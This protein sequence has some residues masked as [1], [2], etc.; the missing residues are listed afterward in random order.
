MIPSC[1]GVAKSKRP[2]SVAVA[3]IVAASA[4]CWGSS[5]GLAEPPSASPSRDAAPAENWRTSPYHG[6]IDGAERTRYETTVA[7]ETIGGAWTGPSQAETNAEWNSKFSDDVN[8]PDVDR[9]RRGEDEVPTGAGRFDL[10]RLPEP[11][12]AMDLQVRGRIS[13]NDA[14]DAARLRFSQL[15]TGNRGYLTLDA[16]PQT[17]AQ[18]HGMGRKRR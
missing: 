13:R 5:P 2:L 4:A 3:L 16:L 15:D 12:A 17:Y 6:V 14:S 18:G 11:V 9:P 8:L 1:H 7:P 10:L